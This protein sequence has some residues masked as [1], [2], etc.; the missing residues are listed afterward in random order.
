MYIS[1]M[2]SPSPIAVKVWTRLIRAHSKAL[3]GV[4]AQL[5]KA[6]LPPLS[7]Y[8]ILLELERADTGGLRPYELQNKLLLPQYAL[9]RLIERL[10]SKGF[11]ERASCNDDGRGQLLKI[12]AKGRKIKEQMWVVYGPAIEQHID[13]KLPEAELKTLSDLLEKIA[14]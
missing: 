1:V 14:R 10:A 4:E 13:Q 9:S 7:W 6:R 2:V 11:V 12:T 3:S 8:D 5:K